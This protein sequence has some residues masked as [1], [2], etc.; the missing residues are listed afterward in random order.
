[1]KEFVIHDVDV[2]CVDGTT[3][4]GAVAK[5]TDRKVTITGEK[6]DVEKIVTALEN[7]EKKEPQLQ[8]S[9]EKA[10]RFSMK[11]NPEGLLEWLGMTSTPEI[12]E[13]M[14]NKE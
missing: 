12:I 1:M 7:F 10:I 6:E 14:R 2:K 13:E 5:S 11:N 9:L 3:A 4:H 8:E